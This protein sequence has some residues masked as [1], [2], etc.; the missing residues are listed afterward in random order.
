MFARMY[1]RGAAFRQCSLCGPGLGTIPADARG[2]VQ[3]LRALLQRRAHA[4][5]TASAANWPAAEANLVEALEY[6]RDVY[7]R[8]MPWSG[9]TRVEWEE[10]LTTLGNSAWALTSQRI[11]RQAGTGGDSVMVWEEE[12]PE[13]VITMP[14]TT[15]PATTP[16]TTT[17]P[18]ASGGKIASS[19]TS[20]APGPASVTQAGIGSFLQSPWALAGLLGIGAV[21][22][23]W[24]ATSV[25]DKR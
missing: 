21:V 13:L 19:T 14:S 11:E 12:A 18:A 15:T 1:N 2:S 16:T 20:G 3:G 8:G 9:V 23:V 6:G 17:V 22:A 5:R 4:V 7:Q 10:F 25:E 24:Y